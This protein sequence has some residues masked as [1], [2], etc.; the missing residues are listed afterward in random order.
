M[1]YIE[2]I[3]LSAGL[4]GLVAWI[5]QIYKIWFKKK[6]DGISLPTFIIISTALF[7]WLIYGVLKNSIALI[8]SNGLTLFLIL[9]VL[10]GAW[11]VQKYYNIDSK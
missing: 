9:I 2:L 5:P 8:V 6:A 3:G 4:I 1:D 10:I 7:L 11:R